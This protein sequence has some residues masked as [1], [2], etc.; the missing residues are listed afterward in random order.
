M[1]WPSTNGPPCSCAND[2]H[3]SHP[4]RAVGAVFLVSV[5]SGQRVPAA[6][7]RVHELADRAGVRQCHSNLCGARVGGAA[8]RSPAAS[9]TEPISAGHLCRLTTA[10]SNRLCR[11]TGHLAVRNNSVIPDSFCSMRAPVRPQRGAPSC[12]GRHG[13]VLMV[14][15][16]PP[17]LTAQ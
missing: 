5:R 7:R 14:C 9:P 3:P 16:A 4:D 12:W 2:L 8:P 15:A 1:H 6:S 17:P 11:I 10:K 13:Q